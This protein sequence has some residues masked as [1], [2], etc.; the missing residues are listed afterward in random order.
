MSQTKAQLLDPVDLTIVTDDIANGAINNAKVNAS[1]AIDV[2]KLSGVMPLAG[3]IF[4]GDVT[5][6][7]ATAGRDIVFD[8]SDNA[9]EFADNAKSIFGTGSDLQIYHNGSHSY[10]QDAGT[11]NLYV[12]SNYFIV[13]NAAGNEDIIKG[14]ENGAVELYYDASKKFETGSSG[15]SVS[16]DIYLSGELNL[17][18]GSDAQRYI[19][20]AVGTSALTIRGTTSNDANHQIMAR[21]FRGGACELNHNGSKKIETTS[22][23]VLIANGNVSSVPAG[24]GTASGASLDT[25]GGDIF[26]GRVFIQ[27]TNKS[28]DSDFLTGINNSGSQLNLYDYSNTESLQKWNKN[29]STELNYDGSKKLETLTNGIQVTGLGILDGGGTQTTT[30]TVKNGTDTDGTKLGHSSNSDRG[31]IQVT[32]SGADFGIQVGGANTSNMRFEAF[33]DSSTATRICNGTEEMITA[34]PN[35]AVE[36]Y[37]DNEKVFYTRGDGV[38][39]QNVNGDG[40]LYVVGSEGN[41]AIVKLHADDGDD[42][43]DKFQIVSHADNYFA[44]QNFASGSFENN[45]K[46]FGNGDVE[47]YYDNSKKLETTSS[48]VTV[49]G[50]ID[51]LDSGFVELRIK[52]TNNDAVL[53]LTAN[54]DDDKDWS[55]RND[56]SDSFKLDF[57]YNNSTR[58]ALDASGNLFISGNLDLSDNDKLLLGTGD[59]LQLFHDGGNSYVKNAGAGALIL[60]GASQV[61][62]KHGG[63]EMIRCLP[64]AAVELYFDNSKKFETNS[65]GANV[66][67][68]F[69]ISGE[70]N[71]T[72]DGNKN[73]FIDCSLDDGEALFIRSTQGGD[74]NHESMALFLR[75]QQ[76]ELYYDNVKRLN[77]SSSGIEIAGLLYVGQGHAVNV[78]N[79]DSDG[80]LL[81]FKTT[82]TA[83]GSISVSGNTVSYNGGHL[84][85]WSQ[86]KGLSTTDK[87]ARPTLYKG[88]VLSNLDDLCVW[89]NKEPEQLNMTKVS[90]IVGDKDVAGVF[91]GWDENNS[92]EVNDLYI[93]MTG[94]MVIRVAGSTT[95]ARGD[96]LISAGDGTAKP[97]ADDIVRSSTIAKITSTI[98]TTTYA[99]GSKAYP[100]VLMAC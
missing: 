80:T 21:F 74:V 75:N 92:V 15:I 24:D 95:V 60:E 29:G 46:A 19:D 39:V 37:Y 88:T 63:E 42:N 78:M 10:I 49:S 90:D 97:Q 93:S 33:G 58:M 25:T 62:I 50:D 1:A 13:S 81:E 53:Q 26:T 36:L 40:V 14:A 73:R 23:G 57:R 45:L 4:T 31:F 2:S 17:T 32:E 44:I 71:M 91:L 52:S 85:R 86:I 87:S 94:D 61:N 79:R 48:G 11:G 34:A 56:Y 59:D 68:D 22:G 100:C 89:T 84:S 76:V 6:D 67:G 98:P 41:E 30:V 65:G 47:L 28:A 54:N 82:G 18:D 7:G 96:L 70:F 69:G 64:D 9:L 83:R 3:G 16:G 20:A 38:Q 5:F 43:A 77:T 55:I 8:R 51:L 27:G 66:T 99:D 72:A 35:G 12:Y